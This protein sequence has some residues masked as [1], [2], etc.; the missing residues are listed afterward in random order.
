VDAPLPDRWQGD[1]DVPTD[2]LGP[3][4]LMANRSTQQAGPI[5]ALTKGF[6]GPLE[7]CD[8][9]P[10]KRGWIRNDPVPLGHHPEPVLE[11]PHHEGHNRTHLLDRKAVRD[12]PCQA[13]LHRLSGG[14]C[15]G[16]AEADRGI[17]AHASHRCSLDCR[18]PGRG[19]W[20]LYDD[21]RG[22]ASEADGLRQHR[23]RYAKKGWIGLDRAAT[24][25]T[26]VFGK[27]G[28]QELRTANA[29]LLDDRP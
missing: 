21:V 29:H 14:D 12:P 2:Q 9:G 27:G 22:E 18:D 4:Q 5:P 16:H 25:A 8:A 19:R 7:N 26:V 20:E 17:D 3:V 11:T 15:L 24:L 28:L 6:I 23:L 1:D 13:A 10:W